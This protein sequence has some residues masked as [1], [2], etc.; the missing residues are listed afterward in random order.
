M[1]ASGILLP[2]ASLP[3][4]YGIGAFSKSAYKFIDQLR[5]AGQKYW[6]ILPIGPTGFGD[7]PYQLFSTFAGNPY[8][9]DLE[10]LTEEGLLTT[11]ECEE[12]DFG[13]DPR[14]IDYGKLYKYRFALLRKA[15]QRSNIDKNIKFYEFASENAYWL[16]DYALYMAIKD[17]FGGKSFIEWEED[18]RLRKPEGLKKYKE[19]LKDDIEYHKFIQFLFSSQWSSLKTYANNNGIKIIGDIPIYVAFDSADTWANPELFQLDEDCNPIAVAGCPPDAFAP[20]GQLWGNPLY[21]WGYHKK[22]GYEWWIKRI[23][24]SFKLYDVV[25]IDHFKGFD[26]YY[27]IPFGEKTAVNGHWEKGP[28][29]DFFEALERQL[30]KLNIIAEDLGFITES[31][32][33]LL[34]K[35]R[36][37]GMKV[38]EF[39]FDSRE[40]SDYLPHNYDR[41]CVVYT[42]THDND[43]IKG[44]FSSIPQEDRNYALRYLNNDGKNPDNIH[45]DFIRLAMQSV[46]DICIIPIQDYLGLGSEGR[47]NIPS[48]VGSNWR[49]RL[50]EGEITDE[51]LMKIKEITLLYGRR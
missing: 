10:K 44:W 14:Y 26:E 47:I 24:Y 9:I 18:I 5:M 32:R 34:E 6:Q 43:T 4:K 21:N 27:S 15:Y 46:A 51:L 3:S 12:C 45:W 50:L 8:F 23:A 2:V 20:T 42:G 22:T 48:T 41:N 33:K 30:G 16:D 25:R 28:G 38:L 29:Y 39:A 40:E 35:T 49:W 19:K 17:H 37:P 13:D 31:T 11:E 1:R 7:S 36:Y